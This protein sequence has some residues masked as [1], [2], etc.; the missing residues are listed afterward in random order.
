[1]SDV[2]PASDL[3]MLIMQILQMIF[4]MAKLITRTDASFHRGFSISPPVTPGAN[5]MAE[6]GCGGQV[7]SGH[8]FY[9]LLSPSVLY[10][11]LK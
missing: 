6:K 2:S 4:T 3:I 8:H 1:M 11:T 9:C 7:D 10:L 5:A